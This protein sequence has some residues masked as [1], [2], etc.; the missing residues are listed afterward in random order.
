[1]N[2]HSRHTDGEIDRLRA[3]LVA[4]GLHV[5]AFHIAT[6][7]SVCRKH[8]KRAV[9]AGAPEIIVGGGDGTMT[10]AVNAL[11]KSKSVMGVLPFGTGNSFAQSLG[12]PL[13]DV[14]AAVAVIARGH[15]ERV[16]L[17]IVNGTYFA[18]FATIG[19]SSEIAAETPRLLKKIVGAVAYGLASI[20][21][22]LTH[23]AFD[24]RIRWKG[25]RLDVRTQDSIVATG[26]FDGDTPVA[27]DATIVDGRLHLFT[28]DNASALGA[29]RTYI[30]L[31][32]GL[33]ARL[34]D[35]HVVTARAFEVRTKKR[36]PIAIDGS[37]LQK[38]PASFGIAREA[39][40]VFVPESGVAHG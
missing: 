30:A 32:R 29:A 5:S 17:G 18:N 15:V 9:K 39:L 6:E 7:E 3:A 12:V 20:K 27:P 24:A 4:H 21:P 38:T 25:G 11:A 2:R 28:T 8:I 13:N 36:Q 14:D 23:R 34:P 19:L 10:H 31:G 26:R 1:M 35:A 37:P 33:Q 22:M 16:D 40:R